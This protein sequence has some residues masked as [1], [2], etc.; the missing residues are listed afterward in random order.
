[1]AVV[2]K[3]FAILEAFRS[4]RA[5]VTAALRSATASSTTS[6]T[7]ARCSIPTNVT[8]TG[9]AGNMIVFDESIDRL[10]RRPT[11]SQDVIDPDQAAAPPGTSTASACRSFRTTSSSR[12][13][14][15]RWCAPPAA[16][17]RGPTS[18]RPTTWSTGRR[19]SGVADLY[20]PEITNVNGF[21]ATVSVVCTAENDQ[22]KVA[23]ILNQIHG[24]N[25]DGTRSPGV[26]SVFGMNFQ[27]VS[28]GQKLAKDNFDGSCADD[29]DPHDQRAAG[30]L[31]GRR[32]ARRATCSRTAST[33]PTRR[34]AA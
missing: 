22:K 16:R 17:P 9:Q 30:R 24:R 11:S 23:A 5:G 2:G 3:N 25:H 27:A 4:A 12:T 10:R 8:C 32:P 6:A 28:V 13:R 20:T 34:C 19:A 14:S 31:Q 18:T 26:P 7:T 29:T 33:R 21:D 1:M 15:S